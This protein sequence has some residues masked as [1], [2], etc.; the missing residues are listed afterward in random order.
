MSALKAII[1]DFDGTI[2]DTE[3]PW[4]EAFREA[5]LEHG[6]ELDLQLY[7]QCIRT[8]LH[9][10]DPYTYL[11]T[12]KKISSFSGLLSAVPIAPPRAQARYAGERRAAEFYSFSAHH[13]SGRRRCPTPGRHKSP[14]RRSRRR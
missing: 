6:V 9:A 2:L 8:S 13:A 14:A 10:F 11:M 1:F 12:E 3:T 5:Y 4:F 7:A